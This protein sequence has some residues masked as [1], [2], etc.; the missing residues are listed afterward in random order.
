MTISFRNHWHLLTPRGAC[1]MCTKAAINWFSAFV[2]A[3]PDQRRPAVLHEAEIPVLLGEVPASAEEI[4]AVLRPYEDDG[5][6]DMGPSDGEKQ[7]GK[8]AP[9]RQDDLF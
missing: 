8:P 9:P 5:R 3:D 7:K 1:L 4:R 2:A 6:W